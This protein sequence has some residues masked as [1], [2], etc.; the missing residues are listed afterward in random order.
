M[1]LLKLLQEAS[2]IR[3]S[4]L[5]KA[6]KKDPRASKILD[7]DLQLDDIR[8]KDAFL[9]TIKYYFFN[10]EEVRDF[11]TTRDNIKQLSKREFDE[12]RKKRGKELTQQ[13]L[14]V[15]KNLINVVFKE[16]SGVER[17]SMSPELKKE[18]KDWF[19]KSG[20]YYNLP[21][22]AMEELK[23]LPNVR[24]KKRIILYRGVLFKDYDL[25]SRKSYDGTLEEGNGIKFLKSIKEGGREIQ[26]EW[27]RPSSWTTDK[28]IAQRFAQYGPAGSQFGAMMS[29]FD[30]AMDKKAIDGALGYVISTFANPEDVLIDTHLA[31]VNGTTHGDE[32]EVILAPGKYY[33]RVVHKYTVEGE[34]D[35]A[36]SAVKDEDQPIMKTLSA[37]KEFAGTFKLNDMLD[38]SKNDFSRPIWAS[39]SVNIVKDINLFKKLIVNSATTSVIHAY[40]KALAFYKKELSK[41]TPDELKLDKYATNDDLREKV[42]TLSKLM[43]MFT[44]KVN[45]SKFKNEKNPKAAGQQHELSGEEYRT[46]IKCFDLNELEKQLLVNGRIMN[47]EGDQAIENLASALN[48][49]LPTSAS[50][51]RFGAPKQKAAL[52]EVLEAFF[53][54]VGVDKPLDFNEATKTM[55]NLIRKAFRNYEMLDDLEKI[56]EK[57][58]ELK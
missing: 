50:M 39:N 57:L 56:Q 55:I 20:R 12:L 19:N 30:R 40:D 35:P 33:A 8:D 38:V 25:S 13:D 4:D 54:K 46:T 45:H 42:A 5:K 41:V 7:K 27:D 37:V 36:M 2:S 31:S 23:S 52:E 47:R 10:N 17:G 16:Y 29:W 58:Q 32:G 49:T 24:P 9:A 15:I 28:A 14:Q 26:L 3:I 1:S 11:I 18:L 51:S 21:S 53:K 44:N 48:V 6:I 34:V 43:S 22:W